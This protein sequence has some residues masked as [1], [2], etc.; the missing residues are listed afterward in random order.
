MTRPSRS[1]VTVL[2]CCLATCSDPASPTS[3]YAGTYV[4][5]TVLSS[6]P[7]PVTMYLAFQGHPPVVVSREEIF[8]DTLVLDAA[9]AWQERWLG[10]LQMKS[11]TSVTVAGDTLTFLNLTFDQLD[12]NPRYIRRP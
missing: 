9:G 4:L 7:L 12:W 1:L 2:A 8:A 11:P 3:Q 5:S 10:S 6:S